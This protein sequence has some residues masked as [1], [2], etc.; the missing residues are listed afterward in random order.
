MKSHID[1]FYVLLY[2]YLNMIVQ[3]FKNM[4]FSNLHAQGDLDIL[5]KVYL[6]F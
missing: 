4:K 3:M 1:L 6:L 5:L 2:L